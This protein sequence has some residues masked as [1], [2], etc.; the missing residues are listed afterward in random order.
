MEKLFGK[1]KPKEEPKPAVAEVKPN[2][3]TL[4]ETSNQVSKISKLKH[5]Y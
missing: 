5:V 4:T 1:S 3:P 2:T